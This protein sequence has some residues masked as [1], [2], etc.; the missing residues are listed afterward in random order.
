MTHIHM[1]HMHIYIH[2]HVLI[3]AHIHAYKSCVIVAGTKHS[4][5][6]PSC[7]GMELDSHVLYSCLNFIL[8]S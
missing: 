4:T 8:R 1:S 5:T 7:G 6:V 2:A 3:S